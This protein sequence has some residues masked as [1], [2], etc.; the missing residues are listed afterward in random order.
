M[1][2]D[3]VLTAA[4]RNN[5]L[6]LQRTQSSIDITQNRLATGKKV[7]S[8]L[9]N[10][11][12][13]FA[14]NALKNRASDLNRLLD[15]IGQNIQVIKAADNGVTALTKLVEQA[16]SIAQSARDALAAGQQ[17]AKVVGNR[18]LRGVTNVAGLPGI[19]NGSDIILS[20]TDANGTAINI[21]AFGGAAGANVTIDIA[22]NESIDDLI[23]EINDIHFQVDGA[24]NA[25]GDKVFTARLNES[26]FLEIKTNNGGDFRVQFQG[27]VATN[28][29]AD[30]AIAADLG[31]SGIARVVGQGGAATSNNN[32]EFTVISD[33]SLNSFALYDNTT[34]PRSV[35]DRSDTLNNLTR[36]DGTAIFANI[37]TTDDDFRIGING[38]TRQSV[39]L[40]FG[41]TT[42]ATTIQ[43]FIDEINNNTALN[44][45]IRAEFDDETG[46]L[47]LRAI[48]ADVE[49]VEVGTLGAVTQNLGFGR[50]GG[51][52][53]ANTTQESIESIRLSSAA[54]ALATY[55]N[56]FNTIR[57]QID[58]LVGN[59]DTGYRGTNLL[60]GDDLLTYFNEFR[61]SSLET[62]GVTFN[63]D[64]LGIDAA[65]FNR[66]ATVESSLT[67]IREA[68]E[69]VRNYGS[70]LANDLAVIQTRQD[71]TQNLINTLTEGSD[72]LVNADGN[73]EGAKLLALQTRQSLGV[74]SLS[75]ASQSQQS[76]LRLF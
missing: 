22:T 6:S 48:S 64:G 31:F 4:L 10:P 43:G 26:G 38:G 2:N 71:F 29:A 1:S 37:N 52:A 40:T 51:V 72:K 18:D 65:N 30:L 76:I 20:V 61:T 53:S 14:S 63:A 23:A 56:D 39:N 35:A 13:F 36:S 42:N 7:N 34:V 49:S 24:G 70:T 69:A 8:A 66:T 28:D 44:S 11:Q 25:V 15:T 5:L 68:L 9:D 58:E 47:S 19:P 73:E 67:Q 75:L 60:G 41:T 21:G 17:E 32:V 27:A 55:E 62:Q 57:D 45:K 59:G 33:V 46:T 3:V 74:T 50:N 54:G 16:D 12:S